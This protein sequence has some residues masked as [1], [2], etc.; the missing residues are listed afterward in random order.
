MSTGGA[1]RPGL[2]PSGA[3]TGAGSPPRRFVPPAR[4]QVD[5]TCFQHPL[6]APYA[7]WG[8]LLGGAEWPSIPALDAAL[9]I[10]GKQLV[11]QDAG[12]LA[13]GLHYEQRVAGGR[14]ATRAS[15]W[16]DLFNAL[17]WARYPSIKHALNARQCA[18]IAKVGPRRR[19]TAQQ[20]LTQFDESGLV[21]RV[22]DASLVAAWDAHDW[23][24]LFV[25]NAQAWQRGE[26]AV[27]A[28]FGHALLEP[29]LVRDRLLVG[30]CLVVMADADDL[31]LGIAAEA[32]HAGRILNAAAE[33][34]PLPL[35][36]IAGW[37]CPQDA[38]FRARQDYFRPLRAGRV[39]PPPLRQV[40]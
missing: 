15:N 13:D 1:G 20:A 38:Q 8:G 32:I 30:K 39:Y 36:G 10:A 25:E 7:R 11:E 17:V 12:L 16:H 34:R 23:Q 2:A 35:A 40:S 5:P 4:G 19:T 24:G 9:S 27:A 31:A 33:L 29:V 28:A 22:T 37:H 26:I 6:L 3:D 14:I 21:V 18:D